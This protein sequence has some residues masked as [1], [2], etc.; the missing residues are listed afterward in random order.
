MGCLKHS[1]SSN[2]QAPVLNSGVFCLLAAVFEV[3]VFAV[4]WQAGK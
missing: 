3:G 2:K 4:S 1:G